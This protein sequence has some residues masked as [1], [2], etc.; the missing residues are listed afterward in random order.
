MNATCILLIVLA[1]QGVRAPQQSSGMITSSD[2]FT[3]RMEDR[4]A[5]TLEAQNERE[6]T[7]PKKSAPPNRQELAMLQDLEKNLDKLTLAV[8]QSDYKNVESLSGKIVSGVKFFLPDIEKQSKPASLEALPATS[9]GPVFEKLGNGVALV[10]KGLR[11]GVLNLR[12]TGEVV[13]QLR[14]V[15]Q[16]AR[17]ARR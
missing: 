2:E 3:R 8:R 5:L 17:T 14:V 16:S 4:L 15:Q 7:S 1:L 9:I 11:D 12:L 10:I 6:M 13:S